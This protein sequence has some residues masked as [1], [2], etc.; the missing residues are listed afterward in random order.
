MT[1]SKISCT[2]GTSD[3]KARLGLEIWLDDR[4][5]FDT[6]HVVSECHPLEFEV[7]DIDSEHELQFVLKNK[8]HEHTQID[9]DGNIIA[10]ANIIV[11]N[12]AFE[13]IELNQI[14]Y[15]HSVYTH[16]FNGTGTETH[17]KFYGTM[18]CNG[19]V[20]LKFTTPIYMWL[21]ETM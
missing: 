20:S 10:D 14:F 8:T 13:D 16:D 9:V 12:L 7:S 21:L 18:G 2:I 6:D 5:L 17:D 4:M 15:D 1:N 19:T 3:S 11:G